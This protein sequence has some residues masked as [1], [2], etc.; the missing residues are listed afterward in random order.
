MSQQTPE[1]SA[2]SS[3]NV[4]SNDLP[5]IPRTPPGPP[6]PEPRATSLEAT[7]G[8]RSPLG[9]RWLQVVGASVV[10]VSAVRLLAA[11]WSRFLPGLQYLIL[12]A[13][14][15]GIFAAGALLQRRLR[16]PVAGSA[17]LTLYAVLAPLLAWG[18]GRQNLLASPGGALAA[19]LGL[20][21]LIATI[22]RLSRVA[23]DLRSPRLAATL[24]V[25]LAAIPVLPRLQ[26][27]LH[28]PPRSA[29]AAERWELVLV[30]ALLGLLLRSAIRQLN[31][32]LFHRDRRAALPRRQTLLPFLA[33]SLLY[34]FAC[35]TL[36]TFSL[37][38]ALPL[39]FVAIAWLDAGNEYRQAVIRALGAEPERWPARARGLLT[40]GFA[41][42]LVAL[43]LSLLDV[44]SFT[45]AL[46]CALAA[47]RA[48]RWALEERHAPAYTVALSTGC[49]AYHLA[50]ALIPQA[51]RMAY[52]SFLEGLGWSSVG[53]AVGVA[54]LTLLA[55]LVAA[56]GLFRHKLDRPMQTVHGFIVT[57]MALLTLT[58]A[59]TEPNAV[60]LLAL[61]TAGLAGLAI[62]WLRRPTPLVALWGSAWIF[63]RYL[64]LEATVFDE[65]VIARLALVT[66]FGMA[67]GGWAL[68]RG[69]VPAD[70]SGG[71]L[72]CLRTPAL[73]GALLLLIP[74]LLVPFWWSLVASTATIG[75]LLLSRAVSPGASRTTV[76]TILWSGALSWTVFILLPRLMVDA[77]SRWDASLVVAALCLLTLAV[78]LRA[79][80]SLARKDR[81]TAV[82]ARSGAIYYGF[83]A[84]GCGLLG[85]SS[86]NWLDLLPT[87]LASAFFALLALDR[88]AP[89][90]SS[91]LA[92]GFFAAGTLA[93]VARVDFLEPAV[94]CFA[95]GG[96]LLLIA[97]LLRHRLG[98]VWSDRLLTAGAICLYGAPV[99]GMLGEIRWQWQILL[100]LFAVAFGA[101]AFQIRSRSLLLA[102][103]AAL[104][105]DLV[106]FLVELRRSTPFLLWILGIGFGL[107]LM[108]LA[109]LLE[110][111]REVLE[112][113]LRIWG[114]E[115]RQWG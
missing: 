85:G 115:L 45:A 33:A 3:S 26:S 95:P 44:D 94:Y 106:F 2:I 36:S 24:G 81:S 16:L 111:R 50:P 73:L 71:W 47:S 43:P 108:A 91:L 19:V 77:F 75:T 34:L 101:L 5:P 23:L 42:L 20:G 37:Q 52:R 46:V 9:I 87:F 79:L 88:R 86:G 21:A 35:A 112:Q 99:L 12:I 32:E 90:I 10:A 28:G 40:Q 80:D 65:A 92:A 70:G 51:V 38:V 64:G 27:L 114:Q 83:L 69:L 98:E 97:S 41:C 30:A 68:R 72:T 6:S 57:G 48:L 53:A 18:A 89:V 102:S 76:Q 58:L 31:R 14:A 54:D 62:H 96:G 93:M 63:A 107:A 8:L 17:L 22:P 15:L 13:G 78:A 82:V 1:P 84:G 61:P 4:L 29:F 110:H 104:T 105:I 49:L 67:A 56:A 11:E 113:R 100:L 7:D 55:L 25:F 103:S 60:R 74:S 39:A 59:A 109:T 66:F